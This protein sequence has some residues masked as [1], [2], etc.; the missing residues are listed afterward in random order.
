MIYDKDCD[1]I[2][3]SVKELVK[4]AKRNI[5]SACSFDFDEDGTVAFEKE[6]PEGFIRKD[7][8]CT[9]SLDGKDFVF[10]GKVP[11]NGREIF[12]ARKYNSSTDSPK[13]DDIKEG[14]GEG[15]IFAYMLAAAENLASVM[16]TIVYINSK[17]MS[18]TVR[19]EV[20]DF[21]N[22]KR[23]FDNC[24]AAITEYARPETER[25]TK[26]LPSMQNARFPYGK[27][28]AG[29]EEFMSAVYKNLTR[30][31]TLYAVAPTGT[32]KTVSVL[33]PAIRALGKGKCDKIFYFTPKT[34][35][36][37]AA[38][39]CIE[40][41]SDGNVSIKAVML[42]AKERICKRGV[43]CREGK[44]LCPSLFGKELTAATL[45]LYDSGTTVVTENELLKVA[46]EFC[47][48]PHELSLS[49]SELCDAV[50]LDLNYLFDPR[51]Y[52]KRYF[53][54]G[55][56]FAFLIDEAHNL[57]DRAREMY[58]AEIS[59]DFIALPASVPEIGEHSPL[60]L[61]AISAANRIEEILYD[62]VKDEIREGKDGEKQGFAHISEPPTELYGIF[63]GLTELCERELLSAV[64][65]KGEDKEQKVK[66]LRDYHAQIKRVSDTLAIFDGGF[67]MFVRFENG[68]LSFKL[69]CIDTSVP[70]SRRIEKGHAAVFFSATLA[71]MSYYRSVLG[72]DYS[73]AALEIASPFDPSQLSVTV[74]DK[75][76]TRQ[77]EREDTLL[78][79][80]RVIA[81][82][83]SAKRGHYMI[84]SPSFAYSEALYKVFSAKYPKIKIL[85]QK[86]NMTKK[87]KAEFLEQFE[88]NDGTYLV[89]FAVTGSVFS[90]GIDL[91]GDSL[92]GAVI[93][94]ISIPA[95]SEEREAIAA[96]YDE[97]CDEGKQFAYIYPGIN[98][99]LQAG[100]RVIRREGDRGVIVLIDDRFADPIYKKSIPELWSD[101][102]YH[103]DPKAL[104][105]RLD[106]FW[107][108]D[109]KDAKTP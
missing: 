80:S 14:R 41:I 38:K 31:G 25:V 1:K 11:T 63:D 103:S 46:E 43:L 55:G 107:Q 15:F 87:E 53:T 108:G 32:G 10:Y 37:L 20:V 59:T 84:F 75:I 86:R 4:I 61:S 74:M 101:I 7:L 83:I 42:S 9:A 65:E 104:R 77:S 51:V 64:R 2:R 92:I 58:S 3:V 29:Q 71:P 106:K 78:A 6:I 47:V 27:V 66:F 21:K 49:Y 39:D 24:T 90:E 50:I 45:A 99:V 16:L 70:I 93:V 88:K 28:R 102:E 36:A 97:K 68:L 72:R 56:K 69:F 52:I 35:A 26:R 85:E 96:Y 5:P 60:R 95:L 30:G 48:C 105:E 23:F 54:E 100:G 8:E 76:S 40:D 19:T 17:T 34:T 73:S 57:P 91:V 44:N 22:A 94:G 81:A 13:K 62:I 33:Y 79:V 18:K 109:E 89:A 98:R 12:L 67:E 82:T